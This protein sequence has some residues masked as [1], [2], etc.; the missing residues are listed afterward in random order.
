MENAEI[1]EGYV[2]N[3]TPFQERQLQKFWVRLT[4]ITGTKAA[5]DASG[6]ASI[7]SAAGNSQHQDANDNKYGQSDAFTRYLASEPPEAIRRALWAVVKNDN[8]DSMVLRFLRARKWDVDKAIVML[9]TM[10]EWRALQ[11]VDTVVVRGGEG[12]GLKEKRTDDEEGLLLQY[13]LGKSF[14]RGLDKNRRPVYI[15]KPRLHSPKTQTGRAMELYILHT[16]E[17]IRMLVKDPF[18]TACLI[19]DLTGFGLRNMDFPA[20]K[21]LI[22][23]FEARYPE[24]LGV[25]LIHNAPWVFQG[26]WRIVKGWLDPVVASKI[27]FTSKAA[28]LEQFIPHANLMAEYGGADD[29]TYSYVEPRAGENDAM[30]DLERIQKLTAEREAIIAEY[31]KATIEWAAAAAA[32]AAAT[33]PAPAVA[34]EEKER[35]EVEKEERKEKGEEGEEEGEGDHQTE[36]EAAASRQ[37]EEEADEEKYAARRAALAERLAANYWL[38]DPHVRSRNIYD[39]LGILSETGEVN[40]APK[41]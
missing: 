12:V 40:F 41:T 5:A 28:D 16:I 38:L 13:R 9:V 24:T 17:S 22:Q 35:A 31:E 23:V 4:E 26:I 20:V 32:A 29:Y 30:Q 27:H 34:Q 8:P 33:A 39:R 15:V 25:V 14:V 19:F 2:G 18:D 3:L 21:F 11:N 6:A 37:Q 36:T 1:P 7:R 10:V